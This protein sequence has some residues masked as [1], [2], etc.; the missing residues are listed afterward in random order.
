MKLRPLHDRVIVKRIE[1]EEQRR[2]LKDALAQ[3]NPPDDMGVIVRTAGTGRSK[4]ELQRDME[5]LT[6]IWDTMKQKARTVKAPSLIY[7]EGDVV[8]RVFRDEDVTHVDGEVN[9]ESDLTTIQTELILAD[10]QTL[11]KAIPR[12][13]KE[14]KG[15]KAEPIALETAIEAAKRLGIGRQTLYNKIRVYNLG[16]RPGRVGKVTV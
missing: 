3:L 12:F 9:P 6:G 8:T 2:S 11:E 15:K 1:S 5:Y 13:E 4:D 16:Q 7:Q 14:V 10:L